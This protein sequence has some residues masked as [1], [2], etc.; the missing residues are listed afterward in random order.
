MV[1][2]S[3]KAMLSSKKYQQKLLYSDLVSSIQIDQL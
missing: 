3:A 1:A 2:Q